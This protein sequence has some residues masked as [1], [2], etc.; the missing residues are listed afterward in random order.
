MHL[1]L[2][3][4]TPPEN[5]PT[6][7][8][9]IRLWQGTRCKHAQACADTHTHACSL[10]RLQHNSSG[11]STR[12]FV[13]LLLRQGGS[14]F[15]GGRVT[16]LTYASRP[17]HVTGNRQESVSNRN[18]K[19]AVAMQL[20]SGMKYSCHSSSTSDIKALLK[21]PE[22]ELSVIPCKMLAHVD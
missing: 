10:T 11:R 14:R 12:P 9:G 1:S 15:G 21:C 19:Y 13:R 7:Q 20:T 3:W 16:P 5:L 22:A 18:M 17:T 4:D 6:Q 8:N 2:R